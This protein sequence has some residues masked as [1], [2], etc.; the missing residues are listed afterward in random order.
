MKKKQKR[1]LSLLVVGAVVVTTIMACGKS[2]PTST[3]SSVSENVNS[4]MTQV[5]SK[6]DIT[7]ALGG[8]VATL[9]AQEGVVEQAQMVYSLIGESLLKEV[10]DESGLPVMTTKGSITDSYDIDDDNQAII[11]HLKHGVRMQDGTELNADDVI[12]SVMHMEAGTYY[13]DIDYTRVKKVD[14]YTVSVGVKVLGQ[15]VINKVSTIPVFSK[16]AYEEVD[17]DGVFFTNGYVSC[18]QYKISEWVSGDSVT[19][20]AFDGYYGGQPAIK[21]VVFRIFSETSVAVMELQTGGVDVVTTPDYTSYKQAESGEMG[22]NFS[23]MYSAGNLL[24]CI[25]LNMNQEKFQ[26]FRVRQAI[27]YAIDRN[28][29]SE[30]TFNGFGELSYRILGNTYAGMTTYDENTWPYK[31]NIDK[32]KELMSAAGYSDGMDVEI[33]THNASPFYQTIAQIFANQVAKIGIRCNVDVYEPATFKTTQNGLDGWDISTTSPNTSYVTNASD[34]LNNALIGSLHCDALPTEGFQ[35]AEQICT[36]LKT[37]I[38]DEEVANLSKQFEENYFNNWLWWYP[39]QLSGVYTICNSDL[40]GFQR[41]ASV[42]DLSQA[43]FK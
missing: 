18:G 33:I 30:G 5:S 10:S 41:T 39:V 40:Q 12:T 29:I 15:P 34:F 4:D 8:P 35:E 25:Y 22:D 24:Y 3:S 32:A 7:I 42:L 23:T 13:A 6:E 31:Q 36:E 27:M 17:N 38:D 11:Y 2:N 21:K 26:D 1:V 37:T 28:A 20:E 9:S 43:Y 16:E 19:L 14:D